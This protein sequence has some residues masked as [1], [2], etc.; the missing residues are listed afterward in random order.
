MASLKDILRVS[1]RWIPLEEP[2][3]ARHEDTTVTG[4]IDRYPNT[5]YWIRN[6]AGLL[7]D[8][9]RLVSVTHVPKADRQGHLD[10]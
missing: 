10:V 4:R 8:R 3:S 2:H 1:R 6:Y 7:K 5:T 9:A